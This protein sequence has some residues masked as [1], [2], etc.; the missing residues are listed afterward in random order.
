[1]LRILAAV[2]FLSTL[3]LAQPW[4]PFTVVEAGSSVVL[5]NPHLVLRDQGIV[6]IFYQS[7]DTVFHA[8]VS[9]VDGLLLHGIQAFALDDTVW[10]RTLR[11]AVW[12]G[13]EWAALVYDVTAERNRTLLFRGD[14][15]VQSATE[16]DSGYNFLDMYSSSSENVAL[17]MTPRVGGGFIAGWV[18]CWT[19][20]NGQF[21][22]AGTTLRALDFPPADSTF[23]EMRLD[24]GGGSQSELFLRS[25]TMDSVVAADC[26]PYGIHLFCLR[27]GNNDGSE[28]NP[29]FYFPMQPLDFLATHG[30][31]FYVLSQEDSLRLRELTGN[32]P[33]RLAL[34]PSAYS[35][36]SN[37]DY[38]MAFLC[39]GPTELYL[40]RADTVGSPQ[41]AP[42][43]LAEGQPGFAIRT[44][45]LAMSGNGTLSALWVETGLADSNHCQL[46]MATVDWATELATARPSLNPLPAAFNLCAS[47]N[48]F[49]STLRIEYTLPHAQNI[50]LEV[51]NLLGQKV[52]ALFSGSKL[53]GS[54][55]VLWS[56]Q[57]GTG[58]YFVTLKTP[59]AVR[60]TKV[61]YLR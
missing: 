55:S 38:G 59:E 42:G 44:A 6:D 2:L 57:G 11:G 17:T 29:A 27:H 41:F 40:T 1:M 14:A 22:C 16:L 8:E 24:Y 3:A 23:Y 32:C 19:W 49:N 60:T 26:Q 31:R 9:L 43:L 45:T 28:W 35:A 52:A 53:A 47:P 50:E 7:G 5:T 30:G 10:T 12:A 20:Y 18:N 51:F 39:G 4:G 46:R 58:I 25:A 56:P 61:V 34:A 33:T 48:P 36:V 37:W 15:A 13:S 54:H 21:N